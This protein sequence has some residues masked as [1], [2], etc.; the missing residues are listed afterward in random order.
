MQ[1]SHFLLIG[2]GAVGGFYIGKLAQKYPNI[3][4]L[5]RSDS[6]ELKTQGLKVSSPDGNYIFKPLNIYTDPEQIKKTYD[7]IFL[8]TK[9]INVKKN[10]ELL[11]ATVSKDTVIVLIQNGIKI[12]QPIK[13]NFPQNT[14]ISAIAFVCATKTA[15]AQIQHVASGR[16]TLG[17]Y[18]QGLSKQVE[19]LNTAFNQAGIECSLSKNIKQ[20]R[21]QKLLWNA[22]FNPVSVLAGE[23]DTKELLDDPDTNLLIRKIMEEIVLI[24]ASTG[25]TLD[26]EL[27]DMNITNTHKMKPYKTSMLVDFEN[28]REM[29]VEAILGNALRVAKA[30]Q[31]TAPNLFSIYALLK[32]KNRNFAT[33]PET[34]LQYSR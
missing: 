6:E 27:I 3:D 8:C 33:R 34:V 28:Q 16:L 23:A 22:S 20:D 25:I 4:V 11:K 21:W 2:P 29:E 5:C 31:V 10:I 32:L 15:P 7:Y 1:N 12:E 14:I 17:L 26:N 19:L 13:N 24:A 30:N 18:P 9:V